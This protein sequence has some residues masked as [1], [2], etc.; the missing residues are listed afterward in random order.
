[1]TFNNV[2]L[3]IMELGT[4]AIKHCDKRK[5]D[6]DEVNYFNLGYFA[7]LKDGT[8]IPV[9]NLVI[10]GKV[11]AQ[12][13]GQADWLNT[14]N[15]KLT[16]L[17]IHNDNSVSMDKVDSF[18]GMNVKY[19][20]SGIPIIRNGYSVNMNTI[21][22]EGYFGNECYDTWHGFLGVRYGKPIYVAAK[23]GFGMMVYILEYLGIRDGIKVDGGG[24]FHLVNGNAVIEST[25]ENRKINNIGIWS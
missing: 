4:F 2:H 10:D 5:K 22:T 6:I 12:S 9:G 18:D 25:S 19:A 24:S 16:T 11:V 3:Q 8:T 13:K 15:K 20:I 23:C 17:M 14:A 7:K 21:K 1:M